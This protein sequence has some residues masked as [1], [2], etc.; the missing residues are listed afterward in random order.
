MPRSCLLL[1]LAALLLAGTALAA[2][3]YKWTDAATGNVHYEDTR[4]PQ[5]EVEVIRA[6]APYRG[7]TAESAQ[8]GTPAGSTPVED[9]AAAKRKV[10]C[11][12]TRERLAQAESAQRMYLLDEKGNR[13]YLDADEIKAHVAELK[14]AVASWCEGQ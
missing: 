7:E 11:M 5:G 2:P 14:A 12:E 9:E 10:T 13:R 4:P 1:P 6:P 3:I 8:A